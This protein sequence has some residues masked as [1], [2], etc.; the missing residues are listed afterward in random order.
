ME[1]YIDG[2]FDAVYDH[3]THV[4]CLVSIGIVAYANGKRQRSYYSLIRP[5]RFHRL[6][7]VVQKMTQLQNED[8]RRARSFA[9]VIQEAAQ[10]IQSN[11][12]KEYRLYSFGPDDARTLHSHAAFEAVTLPSAF[13]EIIDLQRILSRQV[14]WEK[15]IISPTLS[16]D[17]LKFVYSI[18]G[19]VIHNAFNDAVD[20]MRIHEA[21]RNEKLLHKRVHTLWVQKEQHRQEV[22]QRNYEKMIKVLHER[23]GRY[24]GQE[25]KICFYPDVIQ[26]LL[27][28]KDSL[29]GIHIS[30]EGLYDADHFYPYETI[31]AY[32][33]WEDQA[34]LQ[35][36]LKLRIAER[37]MK[38]VC[39]LTYRNAAHFAGIWHMLEHNEKIASHD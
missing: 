11:S 32:M 24:I 20:L 13:E 16:L 23:Y 25:R 29:E 31:Q 35:V 5:R 37:K 30:E 34:I 19:A 7:R 9:Q 10:F 38:V 26:Q 3:G 28:M 17:D 21:A 15:V 1:Y 2:E 12:D 39:P 18:E 33:C 36:V 27:Y 22:K 6:S 8:I 14:V 4:Q